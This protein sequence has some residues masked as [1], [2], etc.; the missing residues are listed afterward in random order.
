[1]AA[2]APGRTLGEEQAYQQGKVDGRRDVLLA[3][4]GAFGKVLEPDSPDS[5]ARALI[6]GLAKNPPLLEPSSGID[7]T[8]PTEP[9]NWRDVE[10][11]KPHARKRPIQRVTADGGREDFYAVEGC[12]FCYCPHAEQ[13]KALESRCATLKPESG[14]VP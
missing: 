13:C 12:I 1:M 11:D 8:D 6:D 14:G 5:L 7:P 3:L 2:K 9:A 10:R 4:G